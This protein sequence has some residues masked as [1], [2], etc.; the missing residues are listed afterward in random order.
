MTNNYNYKLLNQSDDLEGNYDTSNQIEL[1][2][3]IQSNDNKINSDNCSICLE[4]N[5]NTSIELKCGCGNKFH[6]E[7]IDELE[8]HNIKKCPLC[9][10]NIEYNKYNKYNHNSTC[11]ITFR[12]F[13]ELLKVFLGL[14]INKA[15]SL[16]ISFV[17]LVSVTK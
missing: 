3:K 8:K 6:L 13:L 16:D 4:L 14:F 15:I 7:C 2:N 9:K 5:N 1:V 10:K 17:V 11:E 12:V